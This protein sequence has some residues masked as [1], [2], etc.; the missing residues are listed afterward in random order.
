MQIISAHRIGCLLHILH[1][2]VNA[3][4]ESEFFM[5]P[6]EKG[7]WHEWKEQHLVALLGMVWYNVDEGWVSESEDDSESECKRSSESDDA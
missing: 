1:L 2:A 6:L 7:S 4:L 5:G 3:G